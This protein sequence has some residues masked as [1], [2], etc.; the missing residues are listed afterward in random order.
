MPCTSPT[1]HGS[2]PST[3]RAP[4]SGRR[5]DV[6]TLTARV[7]EAVYNYHSA[8]DNVLKYLYGA[9]QGGRTA[10]GLNGFALSAEKLKNIDV[11]A[12][13]ERHSDYHANVE[14]M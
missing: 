5:T 6:Q 11:S 7:D 2:E 14:L 9:A 4:Q 1:R 10:A 8:N 3:S 12:L 13:V